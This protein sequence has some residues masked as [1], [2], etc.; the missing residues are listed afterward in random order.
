VTNPE[1]GSRGIWAFYEDAEAARGQHR[2]KVDGTYT[3]AG[4]PVVRQR[5]RITFADYAA[6]VVNGEK[7]TRSTNRTHVRRLTDYFGGKLIADINAMDVRRWVAFEQKAG[8]APSTRYG[9]LITLG[10]V[11]RQAVQDDVRSNDPTAGISI[12]VPKKFASNARILTE[13]ELFLALVFLAL[14]F[15]PAWFW[16]GALLAFDS[17]L[18][19]AEVAGLRWHRLDL[20]DPENASVKIADVMEREGTLR[21]YPKGKR[22]ASIP[23]TPRT[24]TALIQLRAMLPGGDMDFVFRVPRKSGSSR[25][26]PQYIHGLWRRRGKRPG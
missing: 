21:G 20:D 1:P 7:N 24:A 11:M 14:V 13:Q 3:E 25:L 9:R 19:A 4:I 10:Q 6:E 16:P 22:P 26:L 12:A 15:L 17:G 5:A 23:L 2:T 18:R 8:L